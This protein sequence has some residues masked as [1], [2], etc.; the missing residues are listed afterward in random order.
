MLFDFFGEMLTEKQRAYFDLYYNEDFSLAEVAENYGVSRQCVYDTLS[1][2]GAVLDEL[3]EKTGAVGRFENL[4]GGL[5]RAQELAER[6][7]ELSPSG[8]AGSAAR[9]LVRALGELKGQVM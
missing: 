1:R 3:E 7:A 2:A 4:R 8:E 9:T 6:L 5:A